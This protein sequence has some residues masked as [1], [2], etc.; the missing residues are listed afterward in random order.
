MSRKMQYQV[1]FGE[2]SVGYGPNGIDLSAFKCTQSR[3]D[4][5]RDRSFG[6]IYRWLER[7]FRI[8][9]ET[10]VLTVQTLVTWA[11]EGVLWELI[12]IRNTADWKMYMEAAFECGWSL[13][14]LVQSHEKPQVAADEENEG[15][16]SAQREE[17]Q[18]E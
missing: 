6:S 9:L 4:K 13:A 18:A 5:P 17:D 7:G 10:H 12:P 1:F 2:A 3:I 8:N 14:M 11:N 15:S 16:R